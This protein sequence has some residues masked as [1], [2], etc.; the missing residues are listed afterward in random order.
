MSTSPLQLTPVLVEAQIQRISETARG[1]VK[2][3]PANFE[4]NAKQLNKKKLS[5]ELEVNFSA[6]LQW[7]HF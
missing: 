7:A 6:W 2:A 3:L 1:L 5:K 4:P